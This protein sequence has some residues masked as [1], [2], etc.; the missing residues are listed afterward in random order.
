[1]TQLVGM[2]NN[3]DY[4]L[5]NAA[6][7]IDFTSK[8][9]SEVKMQLKKIT[10]IVDSKIKNPDY[11][12]MVCQNVCNLC[13]DN[14]KCWSLNYERTNKAFGHISEKLTING[15]VGIDYLSEL[16]W[17]TFKSTILNEFSSVYNKSKYDQV[18]CN[19]NQNA[20]DVVI[21]QLSIMESML[22]DIS[23]DITMDY[24]P[25]RYKTLQL[26]K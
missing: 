11:S 12:E 26:N 25:Q 14:Y 20:K 15:K 10:N 18:L 21:D 23:E 17:C 4:G 2:A 7:R 6:S 24:V 13:P 8:A 22:N 16:S 5:S 1:M 3:C 19:K 9:I